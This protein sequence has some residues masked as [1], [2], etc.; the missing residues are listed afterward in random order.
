MTTSRDRSVMSKIKVLQI[1]IVHWLLGRARPVLKEFTLMSPAEGL[2]PIL[3]SGL[4]FV[5]LSALGCPVY[6]AFFRCLLLCNIWSGVEVWKYGCVPQCRVVVTHAFDPSTRG[7][8]ASS[9]LWVRSQ[10]GLQ[11]IV[12]GQVPKL[13]KNPVSKKKKTKQNKT[14]TTTKK[15]SWG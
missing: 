6:W 4:S 14:T 15:Y 1:F 12:P 10:P 3:S 7:A 13:Q 9:F 11:E 5:Y 2:C 8:E